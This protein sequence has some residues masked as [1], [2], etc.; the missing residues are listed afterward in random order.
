MFRISFITIHPAFIA[1]YCDFGVFR[2]AQ[3]QGL[4]EIDVINLRDFAEDKAKTVDD[5]PFGGGDGMVMKPDILEKALLSIEGDPFVILTSPGAKPW[6]HKLAQETLAMC[7]PV[8]FICGR[9]SG[10]DQRFIDAY[11]DIELSLGDFVISGGEL[12]CLMVADSM[13]RLIPGVLGHEESAYMDSFADGM[14]GKLEHP[15]YTRPILWNGQEVPEVL[16]SGDHKRI[17]AF[18]RQS[19]EAKTK[20]WRPDL[21][22]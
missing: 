17:E 11:V 21:T 8:V 2:S 14:Q 13:L 6:T 15:I 20:L 1:K 4:A 7:G 3:S 19:A 9:F 16:R 18:R 22:T 10:V 5:R 12:P